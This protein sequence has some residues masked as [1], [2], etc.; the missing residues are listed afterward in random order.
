MAFS[1][2]FFFF[3][4]ILIS[5]VNIISQTTQECITN[6]ECKD[7]GCC[8]DSV[9]SD[10]SKCKKRNKFCYGFV[11]VGAFVITILIIFHFTRKIRETKQH[12]EMLRKTDPGSLSRNEKYR[13][14]QVP[15]DMTENKNK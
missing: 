2:I 5:I 8:H 10:S 4:I 12:L 9:C 3:I 15:K 1:K 14:S 13:L 11:G 6:L 7:T